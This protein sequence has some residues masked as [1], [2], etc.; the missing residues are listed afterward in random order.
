M[1]EDGLPRCPLSRIQVR[2][3]DCHA[4]GFAGRLDGLLKDSL[5]LYQLGQIERGSVSLLFNEASQG[6]AGLC[7]CNTYAEFELDA[8]KP[9]TSPARSSSANLDVCTLENAQARKW[10]PRMDS[11]NDY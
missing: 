10:N 2:R 1:I 5:G 11:T 6:W 4:E 9:A 8:N 3:R 7:V